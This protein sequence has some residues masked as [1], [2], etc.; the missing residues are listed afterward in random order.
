VRRRPNQDLI[1]TSFHDAHAFTQLPISPH[2]Y[3]LPFRNRVA[4]SRL[5]WILSRRI[6]SYRQLHLLRSY[7]PPVSPYPPSRVAPNRRPILSWAFA[8]LELSPSAPRI[9]IPARSRK[10][11]H[12]L[13]SEEVRERLSGSCN[14]PSRV[15]LSLHRSKEFNASAASDPLRDQPAPPLGGAPTSMT[16]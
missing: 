15:R 11:E 4:S 10:T 5:P 13:A 9:L 16:F 7:I 14:P 1:A 3:G 8:P 2:D 6:A 12:S